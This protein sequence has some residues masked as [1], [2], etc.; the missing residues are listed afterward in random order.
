[1][2][3]AQLPTGKRINIPANTSGL[4]TIPADWRKHDVGTVLGKV[5][6]RG[7]VYLISVTDCN[8]PRCGCDWAATPSA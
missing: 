5:T 2:Y 1:M 6:V 8:F 4:D 7:T 3:S